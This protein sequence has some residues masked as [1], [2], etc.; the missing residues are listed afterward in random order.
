MVEHVCTNDPPDRSDSSEVTLHTMRWMHV[1]YWTHL[2]KLRLGGFVERCRG[3]DPNISVTQFDGGRPPSDGEDI[4]H[5][6][7]AGK[8]TYEQ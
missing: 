2:P 5:R 7:G 6:E 3:E 8:Y 1:L 4:H